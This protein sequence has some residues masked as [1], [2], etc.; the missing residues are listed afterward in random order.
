VFLP[1]WE[2][3]LFPNQRALDQTGLRGLEEE[4]RLA[5]VGLT[6]ARKRAIVSFAATRR[7]HG[8]WAAAIPSRFVDELPADHV[9]QESDQGLYGA[10]AATWGGSAFGSGAKGGFGEWAE[11]RWSPGMLRAQKARAGA[12]SGGYGPAGREPTLDLKARRVEGPNK[13]SHGFVQGERVFHK[14]FGYGEVTAV[15]GDRLTVAFDH[16][17]Q[18]KVMAAFL[19]PAAQAG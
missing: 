16:S 9:E 5:Y 17:D 10:S 7:L 18:K 15:E 12:G 1:G 4:R 19:V 8:S 6:R 3:G 14:K 2:E 11:T 13:Q